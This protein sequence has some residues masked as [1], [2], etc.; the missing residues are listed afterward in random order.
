L[1]RAAAHH[2][3]D[4]VA[5]LILRS[6]KEDERALFNYIRANDPAFAPESC[7]VAI[8]EHTGRPVACSIALPCE[9]RARGG[10]VPGA[11]ITLVC[12]D[13]IC[14]RQGYGA[15]GVRDSLAY[16]QASGARVAMLY[17]V[18]AYYPRFGFVPVLPRWETDLDVTAG[19]AWLAGERSIAADFGPANPRWVLEPYW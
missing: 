2:E 17:G 3:L 15:A 18:P 1:T 19:L 5:D 4:E 7:R 12:A 9:V 8:H 14:Q 6:F 16:A 10:W 13:P 11:V